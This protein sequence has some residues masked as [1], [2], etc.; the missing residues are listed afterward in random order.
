M[1]KDE[2]IGSIQSLLA[3][4]DERFEAIYYWVNEIAY[5][6]S[7]LDPLHKSLEDLPTGDCPPKILIECLNDMRSAG[8]IIMA[9][10]NTHTRFLHAMDNVK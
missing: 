6:N 5:K 4:D 10:D 3:L 1:K 7:N 8:N 9:C 2:V